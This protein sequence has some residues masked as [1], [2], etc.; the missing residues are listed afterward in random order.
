MKKAMVI[1]LGPEYNYDLNDH[2]I[3]VNDST[4]YASNHGASLISR[5]LIDYFNADFI[6]EFEEPERYRSDY[7]LCVIAFATHIT[8]KRDVSRYS[9]FIQR[10]GIKTVAFSLGIQDYS[11]SSGEVGGL[12]VSIVDLLKYTISSSGFIGVRGP[13][14][15][16]LLINNGFPSQKIVEIGCPTLYSTKKLGLAIS[17]P[18]TVKKPV[19]VYHRTMA[20]LNQKILGGAT[21]LGQDFLDEVIFK[22]VDSAHPIK[23]QELIEYNNHL[24]GEYTL[25]CIRENGV[26]VDTFE[27][28]WELIGQADFVIGARLHGCVAALLQ[29]IPAVML[30]RD[31]RVME[32]AEFFQIP[33]LRYDEVGDKS[34]E[35]IF[36]AADYSRFNA[37]YNKR[38]NNFIKLLDE[39]DIIDRLSFEVEVPSEY[40][41]SRVDLELYRLLHAASLNDLQ[42]EFQQLK[43]LQRR[44]DQ[45]EAQLKKLFKGIKKLPGFNFIKGIAKK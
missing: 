37:L 27:E 4:K 36:R 11:K 44:M 43:E 35:E 1:G 34:I 41:I 38:Y 10:L 28:W 2:S 5:T 19:I 26:F 3:W 42:K 45:S 33:Y 16:T 18:I 13:F 23:V 29:G 32:I 40:E 8:N 24:N 21:I 17:K 22:D 6:D 12:H 7:D 39:L 15:A 14:T 25:D 20:G 30:A 31:V 9:D